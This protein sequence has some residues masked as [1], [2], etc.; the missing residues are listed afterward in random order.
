MRAARGPEQAYALAS[1]Q[2]EVRMIIEHRM[3]EAVAKAG[4]HLRSP[5]LSSE[6]QQR[7]ALWEL[8]KAAAR[9]KRLEPLVFPDEEARYR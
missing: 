3:Q 5:T 6:K 7:L 8:T 9:I 1:S 4:R 2:A